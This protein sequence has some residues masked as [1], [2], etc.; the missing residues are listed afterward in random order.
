MRS[1]DTTFTQRLGPVIAVPSY[2]YHPVFAQALR[3]AFATYKPT[4]VALEVSDLWAEEF[5]W[6]VSCWPCPMVSFANHTFAPVVPG[7]SMVEACR[8]A[9]TARVPVFFIDLALADPIRRRTGIGLPDP[10]FAPRIGD[11]FIEAVEA[12]DTAAAAFVPGDVAREAHMA[13]RLFDLSRRFERVLWVGG[14]A[15]WAPIRR[16]LEQG[17]FSGPTLRRAR[18]P[19]SFFR[20]RLE[21][22]ALH[23]ITLRMP[24]QVVQFAQQP[25]RY[26]DSA[27]LNKLAL[28]AVKPEKFQATEVASMLV[29]A[30]N[31]AA[32]R[33]LGETPDLWE[34][35]TSSSSVL[36]NEYASRL[37]TLALLDHFTEPV[38]LYP[39][40]THSVERRANGNL[41]GVFRCE[42][43]VLA[44]EPLWGSGFSALAYRKL[45]SEIEIDRRRRN[46]PATEVT[47]AKPGAKTA[48]VM[49]PD[50]EKAYEAFVRYI[51]EH[52]TSANPDETTSVPLTSGIAEGIDI[53]ATVRHWEM[54]DIYIREPARAPIR[55]TN[56]LID[57][58]S[59]TEAS[60]ILQNNGRLSAKGPSY[61][62]AADRGGW[63]DPD[64][65]F[66]G[67]ASWEVR[68]PVEFQREPFCIQRDFRELSLITLD[69]PTYIKRKSHRHKE[70][71]QLVIKRLVELPKTPEGNNIY[72]WLE[73]MF[74]FCRNKPF[75]YYSLYR[76]SSRIVC[77]GQKFGVRIVHVP[78][79]KIPK[80]ILQRH[81]SF[82]FMCMTRSQ[83]EELLEKISEANRAWTAS[84]EAD[85]VRR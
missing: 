53:R 31:L 4:A 9:K 74:E 34:L 8:L 40:L 66:V 14:M 17:T 21:A 75:A 51:L 43:K 27:C 72:T 79:A 20:M 22:S 82:K 60:W 84:I 48:W 41:V 55:V 2:H 11:L 24:F 44:G 47:P 13:Q 54:K 16:R 32:M 30:R 29:Y 81:Q 26:S 77:L 58:T 37:A 5:E 3:T 46:D 7:D 73:V 49:H 1:Y 12:L 35:L 25:D 57:W 67:S 76:P 50:E 83:W 71:Y 63:I 18:R 85:A 69:A 45:P 15:H 65:L 10:A 70:F 78:L 68:K 59:R 33:D 36:G 56:G 28:A 42:G 61:S 38:K 52:A 39:P 6:G 64:L 23:R 19:K 80:R 62:D